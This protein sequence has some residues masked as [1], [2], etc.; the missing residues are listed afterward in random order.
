MPR[1]SPCV[2]LDFWK[3]PKLSDHSD[4]KAF[5]KNLD[6]LLDNVKDLI[7]TARCRIRV[8]QRIVDHAESAPEEVSASSKTKALLVGAGQDGPELF[9]GTSSERSRSQ[10]AAEKVRVNGPK[11]ETPHGRT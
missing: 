1:L 4:F 8:E 7:Y 6:S 11:M 2:Q 10:N 9:P 3:V 5:L